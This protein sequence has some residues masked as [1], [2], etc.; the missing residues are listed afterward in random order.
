MVGVD[1]AA[2]VVQDL[3]HVG[4]Q[5]AVPVVIH[6][7][8]VRPGTTVNHMTDPVVDESDEARM[9]AARELYPDRELKFVDYI[10]RRIIA[11]RPSQGQV[12]SMARLGRSTRMDDVAR[13]SNLL[14]M[15]DALLADPDDRDWLASGLLGGDMDMG[16]GME[17]GTETE[18]TALGLLYAT[19]RA[20]AD[21]GNRADRRVAKKARRV[22][23]KPREVGDDTVG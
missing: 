22:T 15:L 16:T 8:N 14:D 1:E 23:A 17:D 10:D 3:R 9:T 20:W 21:D 5:V 2:P 6:P 19:T 12:A 4:G 13:V 11:I 7:P 18:A